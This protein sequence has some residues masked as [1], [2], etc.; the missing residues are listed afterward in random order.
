MLVEGGRAAYPE[1]VGP[2]SRVPK[3]PLGKYMARRVN[4]GKV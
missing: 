1:E 2:S 4:F 3:R